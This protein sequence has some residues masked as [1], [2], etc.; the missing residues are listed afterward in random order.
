MENVIVNI[1]GFYLTLYTKRR[2][3]YCDNSKPGVVVHP[4]TF[5]YKQLLLNQ[6]TYLNII[7]EGYSLGGPLLMVFRDFNSMWNFCCCYI[8]EGEHCQIFKKNLVKSAGLYLKIIMHKCSFGDP[9]PR[10][11]RLF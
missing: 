2:V 1:I 9:L 10:L 5:S 4:F 6:W 8:R 3:S 11:F 7:S